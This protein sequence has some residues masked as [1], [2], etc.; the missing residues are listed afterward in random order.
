MYQNQAGKIV[1]IA[2]YV[3]LETPYP[4]ITGVGAGSTYPDY[5]PSPV[6]LEDVVEGIDV[7]S[8]VTESPLSYASLLLKIDTDKF[9]GKERDPVYYQGWEVGH[10][11]TELYGSKVLSIG[12]INLLTS[13]VSGFATVRCMAALCNREKVNLKIGDK[14]HCTF[15]AGKR[16][17]IN[18][19]IHG[20]M[21]VG[22]G[23]AVVGM[24]AQE[25]KEAVEEA[26]VI[27]PHITGLLSEH[28]AGQY[29]GMRPRGIRLIYPKSTDGRYFGRPGEGI[30][31][32]DLKS[33]TDC[34]ASVDWDKAR[35]GMRVLFLETTGREYLYAELLPDGSFREID[36]T[37]QIM[38]VIG[39]IRGNTEPAITSVVLS[40]GLGGSLR[41]GI[42]RNPILLT[43]AV[44]EGKVQISIGGRP[45]YVLPGGGINVL[46]D[47]TDLF[48]GWISWV[49][50]PALVAP[51]EFTMA[52][53]L[54]IQI[55]GYTERIV[56]RQEFLAKNASKISRWPGKD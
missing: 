8:A 40:V 2:D 48:P 50:A 25:L 33:F 34:V 51:V 38:E 31:G 15:Q 19:R 10:V 22:C 32:T 4:L 28:Y 47:I 42:V 24:F 26:V 5:L 11:I 45:A 20:I 17:T 7:V 36:P 12:G 46:C 29:L 1:R 52:K 23:S 9:I 41:K 37:P 6:I 56:S 35:P 43:Q 53:D 3:L 30:G 21:R 16:F 39:L 44:H 27:D 18:G 49:P 13:S 54:Y 55:G 14:T